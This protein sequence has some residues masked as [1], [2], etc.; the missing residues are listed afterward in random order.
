MGF[1]GCV[2][3]VFG[4]KDIMDR[5]ICCSIDTSSR[6]TVGSLGCGLCC[7]WVVTA[8]ICYSHIFIGLKRGNGE[9]LEPLS[10]MLRGRKVTDPVV[11]GASG[12]RESVPGEI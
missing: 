6:Y 7:G 12:G 3:T 11:H 1:S 4:Y 10:D 2:H 8:A 5:E 9:N